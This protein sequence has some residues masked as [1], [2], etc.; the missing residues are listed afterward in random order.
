MPRRIAV[1]GATD[2]ALALLPALARRDDLAL[3]LVYDPDARI[4]RRRLALIEPG[5]ARLLQDTLS[6]DPAALAR[7][8]GL[9]LVVDGGLAESPPAPRGV[10]V[11]PLAAAAERLGLVP[12]PWSEPVAPAGAVR[13]TPI[14]EALARSIAAGRRFVLV[15]CDASP[16]AGGAGAAEESARLRA[17]AAA[18]LESQL[19]PGEMLARDA[20]GAL[21]ALLAVDDGRDASARVVRI[22]RA[23]AEHVA[24]G[25]GAAPL[26]VFGYA[27]H[28][29]EATTPEALLARSAAPRIRM[30]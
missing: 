25:I 11:L 19:A 22:A 10:P 2:A 4:L 15:R 17:G 23:A 1:V 26:L 16:D 8:E 18:A 27:L 21:L 12:G 20:D 29:E 24:T 30:I 6:D 7:A 3:A 5:A 14:T 28:P 13:T 9:A